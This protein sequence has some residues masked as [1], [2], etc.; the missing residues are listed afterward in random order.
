MTIIL[1]ALLVAGA[2]A[3]NVAHAQ[4][5][6]S[7]PER[8]IRPLMDELMLAANAH[9]T[10]RYLKPFV[11]DSSLLF[12]F[13]G[14]VVNGYT[15]LRELQYKAWNSPKTNAVYTLRGPDAYTVLDSRMV[16]VTS[17]L[18]SRR[19]MPT[20]ETKSGDLVITILWQMRP[21]GWHIVHAHESTLR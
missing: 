17:L 11:H 1:S 12:V 15:K 2:L 10:D 13:N 19:T 9:D 8:Q 21:D 6:E 3:A 7:T 4:T 20:G 14:I 16:I 5:T 18:S